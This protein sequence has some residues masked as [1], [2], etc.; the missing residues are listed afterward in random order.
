MY[1]RLF[2]FVNTFQARH[3]R[4]P[5]LEHNG[6]LTSNGK[7]FIRGTR[8]AL[9]SWLLTSGPT[10]FWL[11]KPFSCKACPG[12]RVYRDK[13]SVH[14][15]ATKNTELFFFRLQTAYQQVVNRAFGSSIGFAW[16]LACSCF[17]GNI[18]DTFARCLGE[19]EK[20]L[21]PGRNVLLASR[22]ARPHPAAEPCAPN[23]SACGM[24]VFWTSTG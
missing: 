2:V 14:W 23:R 6:R 15:S 5:M 24:S 4:E 12:I 7:R 10:H 9:C 13:S 8:S 18:Q 1:R 19:Y 22:P 20:C 16:D 3:V 17:W 11:C 21:S